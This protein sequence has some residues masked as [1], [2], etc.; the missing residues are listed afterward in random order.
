MKMQ[1]SQAN[2]LNTTNAPGQEKYVQHI[3]L[4]VWAKQISLI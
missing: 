4:K 2:K 1:F 3:A